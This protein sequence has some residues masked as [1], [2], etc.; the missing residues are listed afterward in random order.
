[1]RGTSHRREGGSLL[2]SPPGRADKT[3][4][5]AENLRSRDACLFPNQAL[6]SPSRYL[7]VV[8]GRRALEGKDGEPCWA[9]R[10]GHP[11]REGR[12]PH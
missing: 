1:M 2:S 4:S 8:R 5:R 12:A 3:S 9:V 7:L 11:G 10:R 6:L